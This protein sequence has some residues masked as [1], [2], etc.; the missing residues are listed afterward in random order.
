[1][2]EMEQ[3]NGGGI[4]KKPTNI[5]NDQRKASQTGNDKDGN[6]LTKVFVKCM[7]WKEWLFG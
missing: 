3:V 2:K 7:T 5:S 6:L 4:L 1:M